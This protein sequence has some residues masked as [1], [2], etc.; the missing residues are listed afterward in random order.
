MATKSDEKNNEPPAEV[1]V[2]PEGNLAVEAS[3]VARLCRA[4]RSVAV[5]YESRSLAAK[6][7]AANKLGARWVVLLNGDDVARRVARVRNMS[8]GEQTEVPWDELPTKLG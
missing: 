6:M 4:T 3:T 7:R 5:D 1:L 2:V 8:S